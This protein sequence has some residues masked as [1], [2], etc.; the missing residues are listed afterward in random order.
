MTWRSKVIWVKVKGHV[1]E[2]Q[3]NIPNKGRWAHDNVKLLHF[4]FPCSRGEVCTIEPLHMNYTI[5]DHPMRD[6]LLL[7]MASLSKVGIKNISPFSI[8]KLR[9]CR[10]FNELSLFK[11]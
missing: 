11:V 4:L 7:A 5:P 8:E 10:H 1:G 3:I 6:V 2:G 9:S